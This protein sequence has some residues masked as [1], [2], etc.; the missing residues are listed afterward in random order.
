M[1]ATLDQQKDFER[2]QHSQVALFLKHSLQECYEQ[3]AAQ[4]DIDTIRRLQGQAQLLRNLLNM[5]EQ[6][7]K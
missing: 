4:T 6:K 1:R 7:G 3:L 5:I 2:L